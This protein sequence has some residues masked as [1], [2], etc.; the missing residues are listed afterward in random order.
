M[1]FVSSSWSF[2]ER[3]SIKKI[4][5]SPDTFN[6]MFEHILIETNNICTRACDFCYFWMQNKKNIYH[7][8]SNDIVYN[9]IDQL[10]NIDFAGRIWFFDINEPLTDPR[11]FDFINYAKK[12]KK[13]WKMMITNWD[14]LTQEKLDKCIEGW[15]N[16]LAISVYDDKTRALQNKLNIPKWSDFILEFN[17]YRNFALNDNRWWNIASMKYDGKYANNACERIFK[18][19]VIKASGNVV[20]CFWDFFEDNIMGNIYNTSLSNIRF[21]K[22]FNEY[23]SHLACGKRDQ[24]KIC[25]NCNYPGSW[26]FFTIPQ[27]K[28]QI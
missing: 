16:Q 12:V 21:S 9:I 20:P 3:E 17:D 19:L 1:N 23:R 26:G 13:A 4:D 2:L 11:I 22:K 5:Y 15:L 7:E 24:Y 28:C 27:K 25:K 8:L 14:L 18:I 10:E 6:D